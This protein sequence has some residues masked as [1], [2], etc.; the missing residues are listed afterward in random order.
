MSDWLLDP[1]PKY[2][3]FIKVL[4]SSLKEEIQTVSRFINSKEMKKENICQAFQ[5]IFLAITIHSR[6]Q[7]FIHSMVHTREVNSKVGHV[8]K[9]P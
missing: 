1:L 9:N 2:F 8:D 5:Q 4:K 3:N 6:S 7:I